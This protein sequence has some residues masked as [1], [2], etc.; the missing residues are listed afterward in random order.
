MNGGAQIWNPGAD[1]PAWEL[2]IQPV[3]PSRELMNEQGGEWARP[4]THFNWLWVKLF[5]FTGN[6]SM[7]REVLVRNEEQMSTNKLG[8]ER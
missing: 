6:H 2:S 4:E 5:T 1:S 7:K 3:Q 8:R